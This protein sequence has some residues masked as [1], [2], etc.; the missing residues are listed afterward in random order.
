[1]KGQKW[2]LYKSS[3]MLTS[4]STELTITSPTDIAMPLGNNR[5]GYSTSRMEMWSRSVCQGWSWGEWWMDVLR[6]FTN[7]DASDNFCSHMV[8][9]IACFYMTLEVQIGAALTLHSPISTSLSTH[10][11]HASNFGK[12]RNKVKESVGVKLSYRFYRFVPNV[13]YAK[14]LGYSSIWMRC[15]N[16]RT[17]CH[18]NFCLIILSLHWP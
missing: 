4:P 10:N 5:K 2:H 9:C 11:P 6:I 8:S 1:M 15:H 7:D 12:H 14:Q 16:C 17:G 13:T 3:Y 18:G